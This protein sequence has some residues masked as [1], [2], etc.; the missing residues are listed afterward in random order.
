MMVILYVLRF[1]FAV[2]I[3]LLIFNEVF[4]PA[5]GISAWLENRFWRKRV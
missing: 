3:V 1:L 4:I 5:Y 2:T